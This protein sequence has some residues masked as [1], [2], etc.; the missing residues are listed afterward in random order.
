MILHSYVR[1]RMRYLIIGLLFVFSNCL[2]VANCSENMMKKTVRT[3]MRAVQVSKFGGPS[4]L[5]VQSNV[6]VP[7]PGP[8]DVLVNVKCAGIN[9]VETYMRQGSYARLP[10]LPWTPGNDG[11]G[12]VAAVG[13]NVT[14]T[15]HLKVGQSGS[16]GRHN[17]RLPQSSTKQ[18][19]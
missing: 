1:Y 15:E 10:P 7:T 14:D 12:I 5:E 16:K 8:N 3:M 4:V 9:P 11:A 2:R 17:R 13:A 19:N 18:N 6:P